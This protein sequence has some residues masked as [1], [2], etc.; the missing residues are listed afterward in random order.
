[1]STGGYH[2]PTT[3]QVT[4]VGGKDA[5]T[6]QSKK[7]TKKNTKKAKKVGTQSITIFVPAITDQDTLDTIAEAFIAAQSAFTPPD[8]QEAGLTAEVQITVND[9]N[10]VGSFK[11]EDQITVTSP[12]VKL[13]GSYYVKRIQRDLSDPNWAV[14]DLVTRTTE[15]WMLDEYMRAAVKDLAGQVTA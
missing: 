7:S 9:K 14:I 13:S 8:L 3:T 15:L 2:R 4:V 12:T 6:G 1:M 10:P 11:P 5:T